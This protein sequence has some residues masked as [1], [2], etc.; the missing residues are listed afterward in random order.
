MSVFDKYVL[1]NFIHEMSKLGYDSSLLETYSIWKF[2]YI[3]YKLNNFLKNIPLP[4]IKKNSF[5]E[6][7]FIDFRILPNI[8]FI[9][10]NAILKLGSKWSYT[11]VCGLENYSYIEAMVNSIDKNINIIK[12][13]YNNLSNNE[14]SNLLMTESF[15]ESLYGEKILI[16]QEDSLIFHNNITPFLKYDY[17]GAPF[18]KM[19]N[20]TQNGVGNGGLSLRTKCKMIDAIKKCSPGEIS[21]STNTKRYMEENELENPPEDV[22][23]SKILQ[24]YKIGDVAD[25]NI[26]S[27]FS[28]EQIFNKNSFGG[29]KFWLGNNDW[30]LFLKKL[31][32]YKKYKPKSGLNKYLKFNGLDL[33]YNNN[34]KMDNAF[35]VD[36]EFFCY[37]N[38]MKYV[39]D[40]T[41]L[42]Y[43]NRI[44]LDG[45]IYHPKQLFNIFG[46]KIEFYK[47]MDNIYIFYKNNIYTLQYFVNT[48]IYNSNFEYIADMLIQKKYSTLND[49][50]NTL[51]LVFLGNEKLAINLLSKLIKYKK[52]NKEFN[53]AFCI[54]KSAINDS[55]F[56]KNI[57]KNNF[58]F[59]AIYYSKEFG[60]DI[61][62]TMLMYNDIIKNHET[63]HIL[64]FHTKTISDLYN[65][66]T[67]YLLTNNINDIINSKKDNCNCIGPVDTYIKMKDDGFNNYLKTKYIEHININ[68]SF[69][70]GTI[71]YATNNVFD[72]VLEFMKNNN[73]RSYILNNLYEN[74]S[75]NKD[76]SPIHFLERLFGSIR[77]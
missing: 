59:Y 53:I 25:W 4:K 51:I 47:F 64:K 41:T 28:S 57:I 39:N 12:L 44:G 37:T 43:I 77:L 45:F 42:E 21:V 65:K 29:H 49:N 13:E 34:K 75:I 71:F 52:I 58:D 60:T 48:Y 9:I 27:L 70:Q 26:A 22:Y 23:F 11:I 1:K 15:W 38:N 14:Y 10:R 20:D 18:P 17:I 6:A 31:F 2:R 35:D 5:Y 40:K 46:K 50:Y 33:T 62:P 54:N 61:T 72:K 24:G 63:K 73:Y 30:Q 8:E 76:F 16:Y 55:T 66:L 3:C 19:N 74:N 32:N 67:D 69:V 56:I 36:L 68:N 7:V